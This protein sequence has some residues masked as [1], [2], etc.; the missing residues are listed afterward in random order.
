MIISCSITN[1]QAEYVKNQHCSPSRLLQEAIDGLIN[2]GNVSQRI[3]NE[4]Q[5]E[6]IERLSA[7]IED[8]NKKIWAYEEKIKDE[9]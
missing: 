1:A 5:A 7:I 4:R 6:K 9:L 2:S 3:M 8:L